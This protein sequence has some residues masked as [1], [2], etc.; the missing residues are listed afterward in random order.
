MG[1]LLALTFTPVIVMTFEF[2]QRGAT[3]DT[4]FLTALKTWAPLMVYLVEKEARST[5]TS[6]KS[7]WF[8]GLQRGAEQG[9]QRQTMHGSAIPS[10]SRACV[11]SG[12]R[13]EAIYFC[14]TPIILNSIKKKLDHNNNYNSLSIKLVEFHLPTS[15]D[16]PP[17]Y[18]TTN[19]LPTH[20]MT[21][22]KTTFNMSSPIFSG[23][24]KTL[25][26]DLVI[27]DHNQP[28]AA[29]IASSH[30][31]PAVQFLIFGVENLFS[32]FQDSDESRHGRVMVEEVRKNKYKYLEPRKQSCEIVLIKSFRDLEGKYIDYLSVLAEKKIVLVGSL[33]EDPINKDED[34][35]IIDWL[36]KKDVSSTVFCFLSKDEI[37]ELAHGLEFSEANFIWVVKFS[38][39]EKIRVSETLPEGFLVRVEERGL[40]VEDW[41][42]QAKILRHS[43]TGEFVSHYGW[44]SLVES[45]NFGVPIISMPMQLDQPLNV[46]LD[47]RLVL[48]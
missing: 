7:C 26:P 33:V 8:I 36:D 21:T 4:P 20:I 30:N 2:R 22:L 13:P 12:P 40:I 45:M 37:E 35:Q 5:Q 44:S 29:T 46:R 3:V 9:K 47:R 11:A 27:Y 6:T 25:N 18:H 32:G 24:L 14:S 48:V 28:W 1:R 16:L 42:P 15:P 39:G 43:S 41:A 17:C 10:Q 23:I 19:G 31:F 38:L 34:L